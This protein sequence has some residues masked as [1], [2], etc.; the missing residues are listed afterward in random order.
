MKDLETTLMDPTLSYEKTR[1]RNEKTKKRIFV[2]K[3]KCA[4]IVNWFLSSF[5]VFVQ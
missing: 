3:I 5:S 2:R 4:K 1:G